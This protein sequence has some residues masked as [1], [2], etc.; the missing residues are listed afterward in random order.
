MKSLV[1]IALLSSVIAFSLTA[2]GNERRCYCLETSDTTTYVEG[3][4]FQV[5]GTKD[6]VETI[7][8]TNPNGED[9]EFN[10][11]INESHITFTDGL[12]GKR[13]QNAMRMSSN[14]IKVSIFGLLDNPDAAFGYIKI[15]YTNFKALS[16]RAKEAY[17]YAYVAIG[18][19]TGMADKPADITK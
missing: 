9:I 4:C 1:K 3:K 2:C 10:N 5:D 14:S 18:N 12:V 7:F 6:I 19:S 13:V 11:I 17:L 8:I 15:R 16:E